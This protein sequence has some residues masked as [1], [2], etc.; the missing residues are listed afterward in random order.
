LLNGLELD[1]ESR[2]LLAEFKREDA[3]QSGRQ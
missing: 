3:E 2:A 1:T